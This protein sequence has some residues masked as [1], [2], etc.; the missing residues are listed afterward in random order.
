MGETIQIKME[1]MV[2]GGDC[3]GRLPDGRAVFVPFVLPGEVVKIELTEDKKRFARGWPVELIEE[4]PDRIMPR[5]IHFGACGGCQYQNLDYT[6]QLALKMAILQDQFQRIAKIDQPPIQPIVPAASPWHYRNQIQF[7]LA[8]GGELGYIHADGEFLL[9]IQECYL[10]QS[11]INEVWP[12]L[13]LGPDSGVHRL[14]IRVDT[15][16]ELMLIMEG[17]DSTAPS[18]SVDIP[19]SAVYTPPDARLTVLAGDDHL[20][21]TLMARHFQ[22]SARS[23]FQVNTAM[24]EKMIRFLLEHLPMTGESRV[25]ELYAGVGLFSAFIA[26]RV[27]H[28]TAIESSGSA[29]HDFITNLDEFDNVV[30]YEA[31]AEAVLPKLNI[32]TDLVI[33]DP[34]RAGLAPA[35][36]DAL[37]E[38]Q[39]AQIAYISC[40]AATLARDTKKIIENGY[41]LCSVTPFDLFPHTAHIESI[42]LYELHTQEKPSQNE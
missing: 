32:P 42:S 9:P 23:F 14:G 27:G 28:L 40:D 36:H 18:F 1:K 10:P 39:P 37:A 19:V 13:E 17:D 8:K 20:T 3:L 35:V 38:C 12:Q 25:I 30:L 6:K 29:C 5:C 11:P 4:S 2:Y 16:D 31:E 24:A 15:Y 26:P 33:A 41:R 7:H 34:P 21:Y 22:V